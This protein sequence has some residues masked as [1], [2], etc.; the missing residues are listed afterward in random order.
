MS[1]RFA[2]SSF[3]ALMAA[4]TLLKVKKPDMRTLDDGMS[5]AA[6]SRI[7]SSWHTWPDKCRGAEAQ[8]LAGSSAPQTQEISAPQ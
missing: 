2:S 7:Q 5:S 1:S 6:H 8:R 4:Y 3:F